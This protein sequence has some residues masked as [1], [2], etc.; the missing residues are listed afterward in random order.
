VGIGYLT[1]DIWNP[2]TKQATV[3]SPTILPTT[4]TPAVKPLKAA[5]D[6]T[7]K[8]RYILQ[9]PTQTLEFKNLTQYS[10]DTKPAR[11]WSIDDNA[12]SQD[13]N[14]STKLKPGKHT[15]RLTARD[16]KTSDW[17]GEDIEVDEYGPNYPEQNLN[18]KYKGIVYLVGMDAW[19]LPP[20]SIEQ[21]KEDLNMIR[22]ELGCNGIRINSNSNGQLSTC[23]QMAIEK[24]FDCII[25][26]P[27][28]INETPENT[29]KN[30]ENFSKLAE[31]LRKTSEA[32]ELQVGN[33]LTA[34]AFGMVPGKDYNTRA[35]N[36]AKGIYNPDWK[37]K[38]V[39]LLKDLISVSRKNFGGKI[40][41]AAGNY[42][43]KIPYD[44]LDFDVICSNE[45]VYSGKFEDVEIGLKGLKTYGKPVYQTEFGS[46]TYEGACFWGGA[47]GWHSGPYSEETQTSCIEEY[48]EIINRVKIDGCFL[49]DFYE[50]VQPWRS[51]EQSFGLVSMPRSSQSQ[52]LARKKA[53]YMYKSYR[54][55]GS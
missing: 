22:S 10:G 1:K 24:N 20:P 31:G 30:I 40:S 35:A 21:M 45:Y 2:P 23:G 46:C 50:P 18:V 54:G 17:T 8:Y 4:E 39:N 47:G 11:K 55:V 3:E 53:F 52:K 12:V 36:L 51:E 33:E 16:G 44:S 34:D 7:P 15:V 28:Y 49:W 32:V 41:Y 19:Y 9:D 29:I 13:W 37:N 43:E 48:L 42:W 25:L 6:Y 27:R 14:Y 5:F 38:L 26:N